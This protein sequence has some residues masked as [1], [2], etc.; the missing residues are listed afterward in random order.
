MPVN[1]PIRAH[2]A[3]EPG[4]LCQP[5]A[6]PQCR[7]LVAHKRNDL[8]PIAAIS[9]SSCSELPNTGDQPPRGSRRLPEQATVVS[10]RI[11]TKLRLARRHQSMTGNRMD[12]DIWITAQRLADDIGH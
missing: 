5:Q 6:V 4:A 9:T 12:L 10:E 2:M 11:R 1:I 7:R 8:P 3:Q